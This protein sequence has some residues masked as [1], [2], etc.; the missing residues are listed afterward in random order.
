MIASW[1][2]AWVKYAVT[3]TR[4]MPRRDP[5]G[6]R[7]QDKRAAMTVFREWVMRGRA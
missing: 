5:G 2:M 6:F 3:G 1:P 4:T 7:E